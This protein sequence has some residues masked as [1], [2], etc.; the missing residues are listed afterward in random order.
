M[1]PCLVLDTMGHCLLPWQDSHMSTSPISDP[2]PSQTGASVKFAQNQ[3]SAWLGFEVRYVVAFQYETSPRCVATGWMW[4]VGASSSATCIDTLH[5]V[6][7]F[8][9]LIHDGSGSYL[10]VIIWSANLGLFSRKCPYTVEH[11]KSKTLLN[12]SALF[13]YRKC[14]LSQVELIQHYDGNQFYLSKSLIHHMIS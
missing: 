8:T 4:G 10:R 11:N 3:C 7:T 12:I 2:P 14:K 9:Y 5:T 6:G 1:W 13:S